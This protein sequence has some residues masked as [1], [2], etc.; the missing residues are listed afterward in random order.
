M[1]RRYSV[2]TLR[3]LDNILRNICNKFAD[4]FGGD[5]IKLIND[6]NIIIGSEFA[7]FTYPIKLNFEDKKKLLTIGASNSSAATMLSLTQGLVVERVN[8]YF[9]FKLIDQIK[10]VIK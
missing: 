7:P 5:R 8:S 6:W 3:P 1:Q 2:S 10:I 4:K 9:G